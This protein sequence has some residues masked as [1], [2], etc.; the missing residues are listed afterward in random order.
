MIIVLALEYICQILMIVIIYCRV[1]KFGFRL[2]FGTLIIMWINIDEPSRN[3]SFILFVAEIFI[4]GPATPMS[5]I[6]NV[7]KVT[8]IEQPADG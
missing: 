3:S 5:H 6:S 7:K 4:I 1:V 8:D 2:I